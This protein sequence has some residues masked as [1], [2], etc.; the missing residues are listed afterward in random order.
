LLRRDQ[1][2]GGGAGVGIPEDMIICAISSADGT[3]CGSCSGEIGPC[4]TPRLE[5]SSLGPAPCPTPRLEDSSL[6]R[7]PSKKRS[8]PSARADLPRRGRREARRVERRRR[9]RVF[10][11]RPRR[12]QGASGSDGHGQQRGSPEHPNRRDRHPARKVEISLRPETRAQV[13]STT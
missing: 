8:A 10:A 13:L 4:P 1:R 3:Y 12:R 2:D 11:S 7:G 9:A 6:T 5:D